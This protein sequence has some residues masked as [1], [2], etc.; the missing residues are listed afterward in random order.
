MGHGLRELV[1][2]LYAMCKASNE[3]DLCL[4]LVE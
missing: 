1:H 4:S 2:V 3:P